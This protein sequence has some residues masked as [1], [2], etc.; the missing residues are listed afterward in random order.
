MSVEMKL[1]RW[2]ARD[3]SVH[4]VHSK[5]EGYRFCW[6]SDCRAWSDTGGFDILDAEHPKDLIEY[7]GPLHPPAASAEAG[8]AGASTV[9]TEGRQE[10][11]QRLRKRY[12]D[13]Q[14]EVRIYSDLLPALERAM[15]DT[16]ELIKRLEREVEG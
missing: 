3:G 2:M 5:E 1:G 9:S 12:V 15:C 4:E 11:L 10:Q 6:A 16:E 8:P 13:I 7:L 14:R